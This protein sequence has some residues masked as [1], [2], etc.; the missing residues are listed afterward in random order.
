[1]KQRPYRR[2]THS[3]IRIVKGFLQERNTLTITPTSQTR[4]GGHQ[5]SSRA[6]LN[7]MEAVNPSL[8][9][10]AADTTHVSSHAESHAA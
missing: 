6:I 8:I 10:A 9:A 2:G 1:M 7:F 3:I 5:M 4:M